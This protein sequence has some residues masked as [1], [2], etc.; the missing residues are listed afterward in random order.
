MKRERIQVEVLG[1]LIFYMPPE[2]R[3]GT[4]AASSVPAGTSVGHLVDMLGIPKHEVQA[5][6]VNGVAVSDPAASLGP[7][8]R[9]VIVPIISGG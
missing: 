7:S 5:V 1:H 3:T 2:S 6:L 9:V 4:K 8:D